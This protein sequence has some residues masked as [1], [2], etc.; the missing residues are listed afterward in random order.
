M[1]TPIFVYTLC[2]CFNKTSSETKEL[3]FCHKPCFSDPYIFAT[4]SRSRP[5]IFQNINFV[6][7]NSLNLKYQSF[8]LFGCQGKGIRKFEFVAKTQFLCKKIHFLGFLRNNIR[9]Y[10]VSHKGWDVFSIPN[11]TVCFL[12]FIIS[13]N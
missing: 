10:R 5:L 9:Y 7:S 2:Y 1:K 13:C 6:G 8:T 3:S 12:I 11:F 4:R